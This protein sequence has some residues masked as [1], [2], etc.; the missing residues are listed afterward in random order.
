MLVAV[1]V[2]ISALSVSVAVAAGTWNF[3][4]GPR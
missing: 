3:I 4:L 1:G 2:A